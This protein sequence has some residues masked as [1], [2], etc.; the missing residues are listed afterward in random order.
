MLNLSSGFFVTCSFFGKVFHHNKTLSYF[1]KKTNMRLL[2]LVIFS[3]LLS[4]S[5]FAQG[6]LNIS[7]E[8]SIETIVS[9]HIYFNE[10]VKGFPGYRVQIFLESGN[11]SRNKAFGEKSKFMSK[12]PDIA[13]YVVFEEP[14]YKVRVGNFRN[15]L[16]AMSLISQIKEVWPESFIIAD[17]IEMPNVSKPEKFK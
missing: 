6:K 3:F 2:I 12:Y 13:S 14:Y 9:K 17:D 16:E 11:Y 10:N 4:I 1:C 15:K 5:V 7:G 8:K